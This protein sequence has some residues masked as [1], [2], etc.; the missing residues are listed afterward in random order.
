MR[1]GGVK[2]GL[3][4]GF[5][6]DESVT[7]LT[8]LRQMESA[9]LILLAATLALSGLDGIALILEIPVIGVA[10]LLAKSKPD[11]TK[12]ELAQRLGRFDDLL[13]QA[14]K[15]Y[16]SERLITKPKSWEQTRDLL[17]AKYEIEKW[18]DRV[19]SELRPYPEF[20]GIFEAYGGED[21][22]EQLEGRMRRLEEIR[23][24]VYISQRVGLRV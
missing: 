19:K 4:L 14:D 11:L 7:T 22:K 20:A 24:L 2:L 16:A 21:A 12:R 23:R 18:V 10:L 1:P 15:L 3:G 17:L 5:R 6:S 13:V 9:V 8:R